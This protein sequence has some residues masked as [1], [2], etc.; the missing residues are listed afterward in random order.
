MSSSGPAPR[1]PASRPRTPALVFS[2]GSRIGA[3]TM[4]EN[5]AAVSWLPGPGSAMTASDPSPAERVP[6]NGGR[7]ERDRRLIERY[8]QSGDRAA[9][10]ELVRRF[11][12]LV[13]Q[14][15]RRYQRGNEPLEDL[16]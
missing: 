9:R 6:R 5:P 4:V 12:P 2:L 8:Q 7:I 14:L 10:D 16:V 11:I 15:A 13:R 1:R 3:H